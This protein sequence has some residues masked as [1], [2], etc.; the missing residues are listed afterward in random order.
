MLTEIVDAQLFDDLRKCGLRDGDARHFM[1]AFANACDR[2]VT[3][4]PDFLDRRGL[5]E[6]R[7]PSLRVVTVVEMASEIRNDEENP[8]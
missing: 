4:D 5:L 3:L 8:A 6:K 7:C 2:F 1:Y